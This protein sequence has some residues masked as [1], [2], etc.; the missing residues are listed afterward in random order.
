MISMQRFTGKLGD[1][2]APS[3]FKARQPLRRARSRRHGLSFPDRGTIDFP[4]FGA[5]EV[6]KATLEKG[7][8]DGWIIGWR[9]AVYECKDNADQVTFGSI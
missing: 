4:T 5:K 3:F 2:T 1:A 9:E 8:T 6:F 7:L